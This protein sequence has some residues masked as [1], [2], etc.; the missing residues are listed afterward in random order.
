MIEGYRYKLEINDIWKHSNGQPILITILP[1]TLLKKTDK[2]MACLFDIG[3]INQ[4]EVYDIYENQ[5]C[6]GYMGGKKYSLTN[7]FRQ[8]FE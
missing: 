2:Q 8:V 3:K 6:L 1:F 5:Y 4:I 7:D